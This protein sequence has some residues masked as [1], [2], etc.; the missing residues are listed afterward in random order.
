MKATYGLVGY[1]LGHSFSRGYFTDKFSRE[2]IDAEYLNFELADIAEL[3]AVVAQ[4]P[5]L[6]GFNVTIPYK[7]DIIPYL[8]GMSDEAAEIGAVNVVRVEK[9]RSLRGFNSDVYGFVESLK[10]LLGHKMPEKALVLG[11]GGASRA[12]VYGLGKLGMSVTRVSRREGAGELTY[13]DLTAETVA[14]HRVIVNTTPLGMYPK[15]D[16]CPDIAYDAITPDHICYDLVYNPLETLFM[17]KCAEQGATVSNGLKMLH[18]QAERSW[19]I[20]NSD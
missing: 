7:R 19:Q 14:S 13:N 3:P 17:R 2:G 11:V 1:P 18:L 8:S 6:R 12:V 10:P 4:I 16:A 5:D 15:T 20:W 9:D